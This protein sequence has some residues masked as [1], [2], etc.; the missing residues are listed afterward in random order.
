LTNLKDFG[1]IDQDRDGYPKDAVSYVCFDKKIHRR[2]ASV[3]VTLDCDD[4]N[5]QA[6]R[7]HTFYTDSDRDGFGSFEAELC[8]NRDLAAPAGYVLNADDCDDQDAQKWDVKNLALDRDAD[9]YTGSEVESLCLGKDIPKPYLVPSPIADCNDRNKELWLWTATYRDLDNDGIG[10]GQHQW[11]CLGKAMPQ[12]FSRGGYD[13]D[14]QNV[15][16]TED[17]AITLSFP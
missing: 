9:G 12:G 11:Q 1:A 8:T 4:N 10:A 17:D 15:N 13:P 5:D 16:I 7:L 2:F 14:D 3:W 6:Y